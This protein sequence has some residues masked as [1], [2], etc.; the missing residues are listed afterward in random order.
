VLYHGRPVDLPE[1]V[2]LIAATRLL[3]FVRSPLFSPLGKLRMALDL[4]LPARDGHEDESLGDFVRRRFGREAL[5]RLAEPLVAG[6]YSADPDRL[7]LQATFPQFQTME[8]DRRSV[9][10]GLRAARKAASANGRTPA[11]LSLRGGMQE[12]TNALAA[13]VA[14][15]VRC[16]ARVERLRRTSEGSYELSFSARPPLVAG[17]VVLAVPAEVAARLV[18]P[19]STQA[20]SSLSR[21]RT[22]STGTISLAF[23]T[24]A[25]RRPLPGYGLVVPRREG[26]P[27]NAITV[28]SEKFPSR[29]PDGWTL[30]RV[31]FGG[32]RSPETLLADDERLLSSVSD[33]LRDLLG[34]EETPAFH[35]IYRW[36]DASPQYDVGHLEL[37]AKIEAALPAGVLVAGSPYHGVGIPD[38]ARAAAAAA[39]RVL[40]RSLEAAER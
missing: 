36:L 30:L 27:I 13:R 11:F 14:P 8:R 7:S 26:R 16:G 1:G 6:I 20:A 22:T 33:Q 32:A 28:A 4:A 9:I 10:R 39:D 18:E 31:F 2:S 17:T 35:R 15:I 19:L 3:P 34:I 21:L 40:A 29:A 25:I 23:P 12:L 5:E 37:V 38:I 24:S